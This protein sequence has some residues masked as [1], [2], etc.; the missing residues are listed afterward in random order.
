MLGILRGGGAILRGGGCNPECWRRC[1]TGIFGGG[2][3]L[4][5]G[6][7]QYRNISVPPTAC[8]S[9]LLGLFGCG[10]TAAAVL[11]NSGASAWQ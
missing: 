5:I 2:A 8:P 6:G 4:N 10:S 7:V 11:I 1:N 3:V 9:A